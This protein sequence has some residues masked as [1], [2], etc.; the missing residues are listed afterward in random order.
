MSEISVI[1]EF[2]NEWKIKSHEYYDNIRKGYQEAKANQNPL[3][4]N[5][6]IG[7][8]MI[9][10]NVKAGDSSYYRSV[11]YLRNNLGKNFRMHDAIKA[12]DDYYHK[13]ITKAI[14]KEAENKEKKLIE[15]IKK[16]AGEIV[17]T[18]SLYIAQN[19]DINGVVK[20]TK[21]EVSVNTISAGGYN[22]Q[23][24]HYRVLVKE[25]K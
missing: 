13:F 6:A 12:N 2:L 14:N 9:G 1:N 20:G 23:R 16:K 19:G 11:L 17:D 21:A 25:I 22:I 15:Q 18:G 10:Y 5:E 8:R 3:D 7:L 4:E 24:Y